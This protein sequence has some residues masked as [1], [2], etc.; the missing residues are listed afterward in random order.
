ML[1]SADEDIT[2]RADQDAKATQDEDLRIELATAERHRAEKEAEWEE[3]RSRVVEL[4]QDPPAD[5]EEFPEEGEASK[6]E[7]ESFGDDETPPRGSPPQD[8]GIISG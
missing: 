4:E 3:G 1:M 5:G 6:G 8:R 2:T 7:F